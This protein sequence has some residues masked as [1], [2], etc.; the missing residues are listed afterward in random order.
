MNSRPLSLP[1]VASYN[2]V[3]KET[4]AVD[5]FW[6]TDADDRDQPFDVTAVELAV[7]DA[8]FALMDGGQQQQQSEPVKPDQPGPEVAEVEDE[9]DPAADDANA[10]SYIKFK[11][12]RA[13][14]ERE[15]KLDTDIAGF[16]KSSEYG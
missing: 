9:Y 13:L 7:A 1:A 12:D 8:T 15:L 6:S 16:M 10:E 2:Q 3:N 11:T 14:K 5:P 4:S